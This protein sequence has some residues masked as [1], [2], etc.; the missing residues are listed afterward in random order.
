MNHISKHFNDYDFLCLKLMNFYKFER[1]WSKVRKWS[2]RSR[3]SNTH[4][5]KYGLYSNFKICNIPERTISQRIKNAYA[6]ENRLSSVLLNFKLLSFSVLAS[7]E[8]PHSV[9]T[10]NSF[11]WVA[12]FIYSSANLNKFSDLC[13]SENSIQKWFFFFLRT[14]CIN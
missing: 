12:F 7:T 9:T 2:S 13:S 4:V 10:L 8:N 1:L 5:W 11:S 3:H 14:V 6:W